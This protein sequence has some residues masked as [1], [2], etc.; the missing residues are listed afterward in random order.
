[1]GKARSKPQ[2][3]VVRIKALTDAIEKRRRQYLELGDPFGAFRAWD[4]YMLAR[5]NG[6]RVPSWVLEYLDRVATKFLEIEAR[7]KMPTGDV[8]ARAVR[9]ALE[10]S[11][12]APAILTQRQKRDERLAAHAARIIAR[13][14]TRK[15]GWAFDHVA[16]L[17]GV[18]SA[19][20]GRAYR[21]AKVR[22]SLPTSESPP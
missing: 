10:L 12:P 15:D 19:V 18:D 6:L 20:V 9:D 22:S 2:P 13:L 21:K 16:K 11:R 1:M 3:V 7:S 4:S 5:A 17:H 14:P 8:L